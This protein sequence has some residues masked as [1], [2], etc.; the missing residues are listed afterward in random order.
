VLSIARE[1]LVPQPIL[2]MRRRCAREDLANNIAECLGAAF[3]LAMQSGCAIGGRPFTRY[4]SIGLG[5]VTI[6]AGCPLAA[7]APGAGE[8]EAGF[9][10]GGP[11]AIALHAGSYEEL[12]TTYAAL[13]RWIQENGYRPGGAPWESYITDP[14]DLPSTADWRTQVCWPLAE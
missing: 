3:G 11:A 1:T 5:L 14:A 6:E 13:E 4:A 2:F 7:A 12:S 8:V 9:L 10:Q